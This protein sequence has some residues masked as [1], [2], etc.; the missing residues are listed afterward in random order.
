MTQ[1][2]PLSQQADAQQPAELAQLTSLRFFAALGVLSSHLIF[3]RELD[4][5]IRAIAN[6]FFGEGHSG[7]TFFFVLSGFILTHAYQHSLIQKT[8]ST[9]TYLLLRL[10]R[11]WPLHILTA[12]PFVAYVFYKYGSDIF[13]VVAVNLFLLQSWVPLVKYYIS[14]NAVSWSLSVELFFYISFI[15]LVQISVKLLQKIALLWFVVIAT[16]AAIMIFYGYS[17]WSTGTGEIKVNHWIFYINP[18]F[19]LLDFMV[20]ILV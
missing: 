1:S 20:G 8:L 9:K 4:S 3:L 15:F 14:L 19:R 6:I 13:S 12:L 11:I 10:A 16:T 5:P 7:V 2:L 17:H 18:L